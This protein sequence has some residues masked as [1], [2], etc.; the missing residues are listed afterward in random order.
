MWPGTGLNRRHEDFQFRS[1]RETIDNHRQ[2]SATILQKLASKSLPFSLFEPIRADSLDK[3]IDKVGF[4]NR[5]MLRHAPRMLNPL[6]ASNLPITKSSFL[7]L[8]VPCQNG[9]R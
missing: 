9:A 4:F 2:T 7:A 8:S 3:V 5:R 6:S 1:A